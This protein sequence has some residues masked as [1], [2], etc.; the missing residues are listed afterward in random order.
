[1][2]YNYY[3]HMCHDSKA[4]NQH[5]MVVV[6]VTIMVQQRPWQWSL[7]GGSRSDGR[8]MVATTVMV[9]A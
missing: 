6:A 5:N 3:L 2:D 1:M 4:P 7:C 9:V 8:G